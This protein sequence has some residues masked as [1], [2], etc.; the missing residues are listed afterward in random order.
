MAAVL[1]V[2]KEE[3]AVNMLWVTRKTSKQ[4]NGPASVVDG[5]CGWC[6]VSWICG[7]VEGGKVEEYR[8]GSG[9]VVLSC[10]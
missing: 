6:L 8:S 4:K 1:R 2:K 10:F 3:D 7:H 5:F 9:A